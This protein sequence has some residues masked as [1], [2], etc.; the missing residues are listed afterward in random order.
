ML[1]YTHT[2]VKG[3]VSGD[4]GTSTI[5]HDG[6]VMGSVHWDNYDGNS[7]KPEAFGHGL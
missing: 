3:R 1:L 4:V 2:C 6:A 5:P 7:A